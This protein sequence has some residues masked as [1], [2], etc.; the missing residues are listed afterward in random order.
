MISW[1][2]YEVLYSED[3]ETC[4]MAEIVSRP[5]DPQSDYIRLEKFIKIISVVNDSSELGAKLIKNFVDIE[6]TKNKERQPILCHRIQ[7]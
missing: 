3:G 5:M 6:G 1:Y 2:I 4:W 7:I